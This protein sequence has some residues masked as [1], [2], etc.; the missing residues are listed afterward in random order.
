DHSHAPMRTTH[1]RSATV[2]PAGSQKS[3]TSS[4]AMRTAAVATRLRSDSLTGL[5][6][7]SLRHGRGIAPGLRQLAGR[8]AETPLPAREEVERRR[9][10]RLV[11]VGPEPV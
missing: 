8:E 2:A 7:S 9:Q 1:V 3:T 6:L 5:A 4:S 11:E 10:L